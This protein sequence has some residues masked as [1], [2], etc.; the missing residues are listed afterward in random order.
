MIEK[1]ETKTSSKTTIN[2]I[3]IL[4]LLT[5]YDIPEMKP[6][7]KLAIISKI[8]ELLFSDLSFDYPKP[9]NIINNVFRSSE[10]VKH[11]TR[12]DQELFNPQKVMFQL[13]ELGQIQYMRDYF[14]PSHTSSYLNF[15][16]IT[17]Q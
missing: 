6:E 13:I 9:S 8:K 7:R 10:E 5:E 14:N 16:F 11:N 12:L 2:Y 4:A 15:D 17:D 1:F 3:K